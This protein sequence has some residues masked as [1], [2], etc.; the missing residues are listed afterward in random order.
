MTSMRFIS[1]DERRTRLAL[2]HCLSVPATDAYE[3]A[4]SLVGLH[5]TDPTTVYLSARARIRGF[6][7]E[8]LDRALFE[9]KSLI[10]LVGMRRTLW[11]VPRPAV[12]VVH[13]SSTRTLIAPER[14]RTAAMV[15][16]GGIAGDG[17][18]WVRRASARTMEALGRRGEATAAELT[19]DV[20]ELAEKIT[21]YK[22][23]G[24]VMTTMGMVTRVLFLLA[25]EGKV[26]RARPKG[27]WVSGLYRWA[28]MDS[29]VE[30]MDLETV[31]PATARARLLSKWLR[32][33]GPGTETDIT[34]W[35]GWTKGNVRVAL[36]HADAIEIGVDSGPAWVAADDVDPVEGDSSFVR[37]LPSLDP[38]TMGWKQRGW[39]LGD[40]ER[41]LFDRNGNGGPTIWVDG[42]AVGGWAQRKS[43]EITWELVEDVGREGAAEI[44]REAASL[45][46]WLDG[47]VVSPRFRSP[48]HDELRSQ[49]D[50]GSRG[51]SPPN[52]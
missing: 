44:E 20:P 23:D 29:W 42:R 17:A 18:A 50:Q 43:G 8:D 24:S 39:Y 5:S 26:V 31:D 38:T 47:T 48:L 45:S 2:R 16:Q 3:V 40:N 51:T 15:E 1:T 49:A 32:A 7:R 19:K 13:Q 52:H 22:R 41:R 6:Q 14:R 27:T 25:T 30:G 46:E 37:L 36:E 9:E 12:G 11:V 34:W 21:F 33:F 10:R 35:T 28:P 4:E